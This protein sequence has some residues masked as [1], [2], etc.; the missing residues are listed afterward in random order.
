MNEQEFE[1]LILREEEKHI[2]KKS[3]E[4]KDLSNSRVLSEFSLPTLVL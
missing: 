2:V 1:A 4:I 3:M